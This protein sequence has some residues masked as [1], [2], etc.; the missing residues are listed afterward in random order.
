MSVVSV[1]EVWNGR[2][3]DHDI[4]GERTYS[5]VY[6]VTTDSKYDDFATVSSS[7]SLPRRGDN[8]PSDFDAY[9]QK[10]TGTQ[11]SFSPTVWNVTAAY[12]NKREA[13]DDPTE[14]AAEYE[15]STEQF[16]RP[17]FKDK[18]GNAIVNS[19]GDPYLPGLDQDDSRRVVTITKNYQNVPSWVQDMQDA[20]NSSAITIDGLTIGARK[21]KVQSVTVG[22]RFTRNDIEYRT[23]TIAIHLRRE[24]WGL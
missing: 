12:S 3:G 22:K 7:A 13:S 4:S 14:D 15:W 17:A 6:I 1:K 23:V 8:H 21:A 24:T 20:V 19:A 10:V 2:D 16:Q 18:D 11:A 9:C 5:K